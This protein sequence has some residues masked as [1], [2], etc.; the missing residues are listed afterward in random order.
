MESG[1]PIDKPLYIHE[2]QSENESFLY[3]ILIVLFSD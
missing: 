1:K 3:K 2:A